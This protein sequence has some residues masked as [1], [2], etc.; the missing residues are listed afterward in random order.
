MIKTLIYGLC[1][2]LLSCLLGNCSPL[3][4]KGGFVTN[5]IDFNSIQNPTGN[6]E[7]K[8][9]PPSDEG[10]DEGDGGDKVSNITQN[11]GE[12][13]T[14]KDTAEKGTAPITRALWQ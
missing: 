1:I 4:E 14:G 10:D 5:T 12:E 13:F 2:L 8:P 7:E 11:P 9:N 6:T 3:R